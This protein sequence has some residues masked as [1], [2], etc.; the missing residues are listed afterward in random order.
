MSSTQAAWVE[1]WL[2]AG[3]QAGLLAAIDLHFARYAARS[4][5]ASVRMVAALVSRS[6]REGHVCLPLDEVAPLTTTVPD[7]GAPPEPNTLSKHALLAALRG[8]VAVEVLGDLPVRREQ[9]EQP[10]E[11]RPLVV[12]AGGRVYLRRYFEHEMLLA[13]HLV[14]ISAGRGKVEVP[15]L[16]EELF[17][18]GASDPRQRAAVEMVLCEDLSIISGGP[19]TGKTSTVV[20][21]LALLGAA[22]RQAGA[23]P[24]RVLL[25]APTGK[26]AGRLSE[27]VRSA[28]AYLARIFAEQVPIDVPEA[29]TIH[30][31]LG[32]LPGQ[33]TRF[34]RGETQPFDADVVLVDEASMV[35]LSLM[36]HLC[37]AIRTGTKLILLG[38]RDQ[39]ASVEAGSVLSELCDALTTSGEKRFGG[40][41]QLTKSFRFSEQ[42]G[43]YRL[44]QAIRQGNAQDVQ[45]LLDSPPPDVAHH[46]SSLAGAEADVG[47]ELIEGYARALA[48]SD[49]ATVLRALEA[50]R[51]LCAHRQGPAG[52]SA[53]NELVVEGLRRRGLL[54][55]EG[56]FYRGRMILVTQND[57]SVGLANGD[58]GLVW[59]D[60]DG[61]IR[62][63]F[64]RPGG[65]APRPLS[66]AEL[67]SHETAFAMTIHKSQGS[68]YEHVCVLL[69]D[70][71]SPLLSRELLYTAVTRAKARLTL[72]GE[73]ASIERSVLCRVQRHSGLAAR[74][75]AG[76]QPPDA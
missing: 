2:L 15:A 48:G 49:A 52:V 12:D 57:A 68:E 51:V 55:S 66:P 43:I 27:S 7:V 38:D 4:T 20:K 23:N 19:G 31:A 40:F 69:P 71:A 21:I 64:P 29:T 18:Q 25:L 46:D 35:D 33:R 26:A 14:R 70:A 3:R 63:F 47:D 30:R 44:A 39:L 54:G 22:R 75:L 61:R 53:T 73:R 9:R 41:I 10:E 60:H 62:V 1:S 59:P 74:L 45:A 37:A 34:R 16:V 58:M 56:E 32:M 24:P 72:V 11:L 17:P 76:R 67:P 28:S 50:F 36:R 65:G 6:L 8:S 5:E 13:E 42:S